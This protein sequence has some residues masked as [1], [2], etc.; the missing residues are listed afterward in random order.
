M[1][2]PWIVCIGRSVIL[3]RMLCS[4]AHVML[5]TSTPAVSRCQRIPWFFWDIDCLD[6][7][8]IL[9][10]WGR[11][12]GPTVIIGYRNLSYAVEQM[13]LSMIQDT[14]ASY[15]YLPDHRVTAY[16]GRITLDPLSAYRWAL[17][18]SHMGKTGRSPY[19]AEAG[20]C[21]RPMYHRSKGPTL[22]HGHMGGFIAARASPTPDRR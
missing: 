9:V 10:G 13:P 2:R 17:R 7:W 11:A 18:Q 4:V 1:N 3:K 19:L 21:D 8:D 20:R 15:D 5:D 6:G 16:P 12:N 14:G 22:R